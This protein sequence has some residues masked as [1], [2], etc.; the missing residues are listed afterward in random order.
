[1]GVDFAVPP[2]ARI[3]DYVNTDTR[4]GCDSCSEFIWNGPDAGGDRQVYTHIKVVVF[5]DSATENLAAQGYDVADV[6]GAQEAYMATQTG[7][8]IDV[9]NQPFKTLDMALEA[10]TSSGRRVHVDAVFPVGSAGE[11]MVRDLVASI[12]IR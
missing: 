1:M 2:G 9:D 11:Q 10:W 8:T 5:P 7:E 12:V 6:R 4:S 3:D